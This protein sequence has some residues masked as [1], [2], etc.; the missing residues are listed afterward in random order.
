V[1]AY[2]QISR[3]HG[4]VV[5]VAGVRTDTVPAR[6]IRLYPVPFRDLD[7]GSRFV[8]YQSISLE[9][10]PSSDSRP[11]SVKPNTDSIQ[12][13]ET[14]SA[15]KGW[16]ARRRL[17]EPLMRDS[18]CGLL[19]EQQDH[20]TSLGIF[21]PRDIAKLDIEPDTGAWDP[22]KQAVIDQPSLFVPDKTRLEK[23]PFRF[24]YRY[25]CADASCAG[26]DQ[27]IID[28]EIGEAFRK[29]RARYGQA[30]ALKEI[31]RKWLD[32]L[33][34]P[35]RDTAFIVG[36]QHQHPGSFLVLSVFWPPRSAQ[37]SDRDA[38]QRRRHSVKD[39]LTMTLP[40]FPL[41]AENRNAGL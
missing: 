27:S 15:A 12:C 6:W 8:K 24:K 19:R 13:G 33:C 5:C 37:P 39:D 23:V 18:M 21:R 3:K 30:G 20:G 29:W 4:E 14:L 22:E 11:E 16:L 7:F 10:R 26:H 38:G 35:G 28:W 17:L 2:P 34:S 36:N 1:K 32:D 40:F 41:D 25:R 31:Q 9:T